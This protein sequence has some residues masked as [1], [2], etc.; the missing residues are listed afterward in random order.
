MEVD[1]VEVDSAV[2]KG[3]LATAKRS[4]SVEMRDPSEF[5]PPRRGSRLPT[6]SSCRTHSRWSVKMSVDFSI[7]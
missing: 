5:E 7:A 2:L 3:A 1:S 4:R 6:R